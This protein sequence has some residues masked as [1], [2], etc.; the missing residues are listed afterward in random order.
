MPSLPVFYISLSLTGQTRRCMETP[1]LISGS[2]RFRLYDSRTTSV[3]SVSHDSSV[4]RCV[5]DICELNFPNLRTLQTLRTCHVQPRRATAE[6]RRGFNTWQQAEFLASCRLHRLP[7]PAASAKTIVCK[8][9]SSQYQPHH[10]R[11]PP[12]S[13][14][15]FHLRR[16]ITSRHVEGR[17]SVE[18]AMAATAS[19]RRTRRVRPDREDARFGGGFTHGML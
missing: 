1:K 5:E 13:L 8:P 10:V 18:A 12:I 2:T 17:G 19:G 4:G 3:Q 7:P 14:L 9:V 16:A 15:L 6:F 11:I